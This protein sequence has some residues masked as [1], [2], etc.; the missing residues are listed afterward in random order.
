VRKR[1][2]DL[3]LLVIYLDRMVFA[4]HHIIAAVGVD[5]K[6]YKHILGLAKAVERMRQCALN[7]SMI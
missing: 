3:E 6:G 7:C 5:R 4:E 2:E 1:L